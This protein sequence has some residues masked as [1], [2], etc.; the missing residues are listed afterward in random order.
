LKTNL[1]HVRAAIDVPPLAYEGP[2]LNIRKIRMRTL[3]LPEL[4]RNGTISLTAAAFLILC[5]TLRINITI[6]GEPATGKTTLA[7]A[8]NLLAPPNWRRIAIEDALESVT[9]NEKG[10]HK[11]TFRVDPFDSLE[12][13]IATKSN[14]IIRLLHRSPDWVFL[15]EI[16]T[17]EHSA[18]M[19]HALSAGIRGIQTCHANSN[20]E[21]LLRWEVHHNIPHVCFQGLGLLV[22]MVKELIQGRIIRR[23]A[24]ISELCFEEG[25]YSLVTLFDWN[26]STGHLEQKVRDIISPLIIRACQFQKISQSDLL[27]RFES[28][29]RT[30][31][32]LVSKEE[33]IPSKIV[34]TFDQIHAN[35]FSGTPNPSSTRSN[36]SPNGRE[37][38][39][40]HQ[41]PS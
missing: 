31:A 15:G 23:V 17:A 32:E 27:N 41:V 12:N 3:T 9:V 24:Q 4:I 2:H 5:M 14:E 35:I 10:R 21:L 33:D 28:Y 39:G 22:H 29:Q 6:G 13:G 34:S 37:S 11:V 26:K 19:F 20:S 40:L 1:F 18:A 16:Q 36:K 7:N 8:I 30:L 25:K 38:I